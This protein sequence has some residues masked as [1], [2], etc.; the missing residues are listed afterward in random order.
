MATVVVI[1][2]DVERLVLFTRVMDSH[3]RFIQMNCEFLIFAIAK[4]YACFN[5]K[6]VVAISFYP[7]TDLSPVF[8]QLVVIKRKN[9]VGKLQ[10]GILDSAQ[11]C[12]LPGSAERIQ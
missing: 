3:A 8:P 4:A 10:D 12:E 9:L 1:S 2:V 11:R 5:T 6:E 7:T